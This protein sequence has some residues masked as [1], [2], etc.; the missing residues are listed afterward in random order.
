MCYRWLLSVFSG[1]MLIVLAAAPGLIIGHPSVLSISTPMPGV[2]TTSREIAYVSHNALF[3]V[4]IDGSDPQAIVT[5]DVVDNPSWSPDGK[6]L[7]FLGACPE[8]YEL[9]VVNADGSGLQQLT[10]TAEVYEI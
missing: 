4:N 6:Q 7:I 1:I 10:H 3:I 5:S 8:V 9:C 2:D